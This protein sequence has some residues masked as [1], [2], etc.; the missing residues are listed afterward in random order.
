MKSKAGSN[1]WR[2]KMDRS[3]TSRN[4]QGVAKNVE[5]QSV[6]LLLFSCTPPQSISILVAETKIRNYNAFPLMTH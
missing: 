1:D 4:A 2:K 5:K 6:I 3:T